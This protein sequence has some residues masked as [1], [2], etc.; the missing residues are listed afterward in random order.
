MRNVLRF[1][2]GWCLNMLWCSIQTRSVSVLYLTYDRGLAPQT[3]AIVRLLFCTVLYKSCKKQKL[4]TKGQQ[5]LTS[6]MTNVGRSTNT[7]YFLHAN[8][9]YMRPRSSLLHFARSW[10][11]QPLKNPKGPADFGAFRYFTLTMDNKAKLLPA[12]RVA[13]RNQDVWYVRDSR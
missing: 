8:H 2:R 13:A 12:K 5:A 6:C 7:Y 4:P 9:T 3:H 1:F 10:R 11:Q